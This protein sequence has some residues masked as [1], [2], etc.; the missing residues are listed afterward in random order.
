MLRI[1]HLV[2]PSCGICFVEPMG[3]KS[4]FG[5]R[6][7]RVFRGWFVYCEI[8]RGRVGGIRTPGHRIRNQVLYPTELLPRTIQSLGDWKRRYVVSFR[9][10]KMYS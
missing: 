8:V 10:V 6:S 5:L 1:A 7:P 9:F 3:F 2:I 4:L